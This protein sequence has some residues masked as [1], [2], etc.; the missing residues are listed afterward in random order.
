MKGGM[1][2]RIIKQIIRSLRPAPKG[3]NVRNVR[4]KN[5]VY[6]MVEARQ[7]EAAQEIDL[8]YRKQR[9]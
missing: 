4:V 5:L 2:M 7:S 8:M 3:R 6:N 9:A 1:E